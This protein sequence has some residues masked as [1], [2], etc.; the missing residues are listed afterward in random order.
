MKG[1][2]APCSKAD[3]VRSSSHSQ[4]PC[5]E[6][7]AGNTW[8]HCGLGG[9]LQIFSDTLGGWPESDNVASG[10]ERGELA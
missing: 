6:G 9:D 4:Y 3:C 1:V 2:S 10:E 7:G 8:Q 5:H